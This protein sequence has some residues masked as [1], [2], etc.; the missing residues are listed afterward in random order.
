V[1]SAALTTGLAYAGNLARNPNSGSGNNGNDVIGDTVAQQANRIGEKIIDK[2][3]DVQPTITVRQ[4][5]PLRVLVNK[6]MILEPYV[7]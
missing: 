6:D 1:E 7:P 2:E 5:W 4:G 3:L